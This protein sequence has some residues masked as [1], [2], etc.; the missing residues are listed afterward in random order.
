MVAP[1]NNSKRLTTFAMPAYQRIGEELRARVEGRYWS[2]GAML[3]SRKEL[4]AE[5][6]VSVPTIERAVADLLTEGALR[7]DHRGTF[8]VGPPQESGV[9]PVRPAAS[10]TVGLIATL[11]PS[12]DRRGTT[13][14]WAETITKALERS[15]VQSRVITRFFNLKRPDGTTATPVQA[16][17]ALLAEGVDAIVVVL[18]TAEQ[19]LQ[20][21]APAGV[22]LVFVTDFRHSHPVQS[23][24][25][26]NQDAGYQA[27]HHLFEQGCPD[28]LFFAPYT[29]DWVE[30]RLAGV[31]QAALLAGR[32]A[33]AVRSRISQALVTEFTSP[34]GVHRELAYAAARSLLAGGLPARGVVA[35]NDKV[36]LGFQQ[37]AAEIGLT[38]GRDYALLGFDDDPL[39]REAGL[40]SLHPP[41]EGLGQEA[42]R[43]LLSA[44]SSQTLQ[45]QVCL[46]SH[47]VRR[48][49]SRVSFSPDCSPTASALSQASLATA[50]ERDTRHDTAF[51]CPSL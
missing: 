28:L 50:H 38:A 27:A 19:V 22:P 49:S 46:H 10:A 32:P 48:A 47:L 16:R 3:P 15:L 7:A 34:H 5:F 13:P 41:L 40:T 51:L 1:Q 12:P 4:A 2:S 24:C 45:Q 31:R 21:A 33:E 30:S 11:P 9:A 26:D 42:A 18:A 23:V 37:A 14:Q 17:E 6:G 29:S 43:L 8:V 35:V 25:Y 36:A 39:A 20:M 44:L